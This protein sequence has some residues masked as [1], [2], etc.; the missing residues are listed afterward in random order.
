[1]RLVKCS[2]CS[3][4]LNGD[5]GACPV[6][7]VPIWPRPHAPKC[8]SE[9]WSAMSGPARAALVFKAIGCIISI[10]LMGAISLRAMLTSEQSAPGPPSQAKN[11]SRSSPGVAPVYPAPP[12]RSE[13]LVRSRLLA[14]D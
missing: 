9:G 7:G 8:D 12:V 2:G 11:T 5:W 4:E 13:D 10:Y 14:A 1:M 3:S 6:C